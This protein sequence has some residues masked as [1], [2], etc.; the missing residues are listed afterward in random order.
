MLGKKFIKIKLIKPFMALNSLNLL[1]GMIFALVGTLIIL[2]GVPFGLPGIYR[3]ILHYKK[4]DSKKANKIF[5]KQVIS[6]S[7][8]WYIFIFYY[9]GIYR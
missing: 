1:F 9:Y 6:I 5:W 7:I 8:F 4:Y 2:F 3:L